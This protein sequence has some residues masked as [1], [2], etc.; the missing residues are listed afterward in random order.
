MVAAVLE[1]DC[2]SSKHRG[3]MQALPSAVLA[4]TGSE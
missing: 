1:V 2:H 3:K 4:H